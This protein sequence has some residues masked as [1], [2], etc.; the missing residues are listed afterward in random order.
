MR[1]TTPPPLAGAAPQS[2][3]AVVGHQEDVVALPAPPSQ[4]LP[5]TTLATGVASPFP[6]RMV[7]GV[8]AHQVTPAEIGGAIE[9]L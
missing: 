5:V 1:S 2:M 9:F 7:G 8:A 3:P 4:H 6:V